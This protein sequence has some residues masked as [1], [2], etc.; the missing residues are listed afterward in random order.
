MIEMML[1]N[2]QPMTERT[3]F[4][5]RPMRS[6]KA[7]ASNEVAQA[8]DS[9]PFISLHAGKVG[10]RH[11]DTHMLTPGSECK[12]GSRK[13]AFIIDTPGS[14]QASSRVNES[15]DV[16]IDESRLF[17]PGRRTFTRHRT[18]NVRPGSSIIR[19]AHLEISGQRLGHT[20]DIM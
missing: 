9:P 19:H 11:A 15:E 7:E 12:P 6:R 8:I 20:G 4:E 16:A 17:I 3:A 13:I 18:S 14:S 10:F 2:K 1:I 5:E